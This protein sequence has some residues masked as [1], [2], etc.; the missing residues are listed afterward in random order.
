MVWEDT[1]PVF[2]QMDVGGYNYQ[3]ARY[4]PDHEKFPQ[5]IM[6][7]SE[8]LAKEAFEN[9]E[10]VEKHPYV[11]GDFVW[12][13][14]DYIG[15]A[16]I[17]KSIFSTN[18]E[19]RIEHIS[20]WPWYNAWCGDI[21]LIGNRKPQLLYRNVIW[22]ES[23]L[24]LAVHEPIPEGMYEIVSA[25]GWP[26]E[27]QSWNWQGNEGKSLEVTIY[28]S[29]PEVRLELNGRE[30]GIKEISA[31]DRLTAKFNVP[32]EPG[33]L[34]VSGIVNGEVV[35]SKSL[36]TTGSPDQIELI[37]ERS[38]IKACRGE[39]AYIKINALDADENL[40]PDTSIP[41]TVNIAGPAELLAAGNASPFA[42]GSIQDKN[43]NLFQGLG[44]VII[45]STGEPGTIRVNV[46]SDGL[47]SGQ[48][49][50]T[51]R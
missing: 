51:A 9:W 10:L 30:T 25:W 37:T 36:V 24:E 20:D 48:S 29:Y 31:G 40:V 11:I 7:G 23:N 34:K 1:E 13:C 21:D 32:Y 43:F 15:E 5:R 39:I 6:Y 12:T 46:D 38:I 49:E 45:R 33:E 26:K 17:G 22:G 42:E 2:E 14:M 3:W 19:G 35:E 16:G 4:E 18:N 50:I 47:E 28:S 8:S 41:A 27:Y 44:L